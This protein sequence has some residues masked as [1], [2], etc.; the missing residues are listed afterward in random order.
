MRFPNFVRTG[1]VLPAGKRR[2][3]R[4]EEKKKP[5]TEKGEERSNNSTYVMVMRVLR[6]GGSFHINCSEDC[7]TGEYHSA[8]GTQE[9]HEEGKTRKGG[10]ILTIKT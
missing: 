2:Q 1:A 3:T 4:H 10:K 8:L 5:K 7:G 6:K 9:G